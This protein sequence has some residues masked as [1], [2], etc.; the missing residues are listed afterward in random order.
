[1]SPRKRAISFARQYLRTNVP[2]LSHRKRR[3]IAIQAPLI[4]ATMAS[5]MMRPP[6]SLVRTYLIPKA[7]LAEAYGTG[8]PSH[9]EVRASLRKVRA[10]LTELELVTPVSKKMWQS[11]GIWEEP[12]IP[13]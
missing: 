3:S 1:M 8:T 7:V 9:D 4:L 13:D 5:V 2:K 12:H 6:R 10:L 11:F